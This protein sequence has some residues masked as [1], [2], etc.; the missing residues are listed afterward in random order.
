MA[1][2]L[3]YPDIALWLP[4][5]IQTCTAGKRPMGAFRR[6]R[7]GGHWATTARERGRCTPSRERSSLKKKH[8]TYPCDKRRELEI[9]MRRH[10]K[11]R[12]AV[13]VAVCPQVVTCCYCPQSTRFNARS[14]VCRHRRYWSH[15]YSWATIR[16][17]HRILHVYACIYRYNPYTPGELPAPQLQNIALLPVAILS[18]H[19]NFQV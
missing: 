10:Y 6:C 18:I 4:N 11:E 5:D 14:S 1:S 16:E 2:R 15:A 17:D 3:T 13:A 12:V 7:C 19:R 9:P 8:S